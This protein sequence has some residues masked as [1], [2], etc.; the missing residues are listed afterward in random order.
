LS[1]LLSNYL[2]SKRLHS[3]RKCD[4]K[5]HTS[6]RIRWTQ[7]VISYNNLVTSWLE[8]SCLAAMEQQQNK[9]SQEEFEV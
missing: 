5:L 2:G 4:R 6:D 9:Q 7:E 1:L 3:L 8:I